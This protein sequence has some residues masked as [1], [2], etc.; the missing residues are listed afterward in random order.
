MKPVN[1]IFLLLLF[2]LTPGLLK[3]SD[4]NCEYPNIL[5]VLDKSSSMTHGISGVTKWQIAK[6]AI[7]TFLT[8]NQAKI[9]FGLML[10]PDPDKCNPGKVLVHLKEN[11]H[12]NILLELSSPPPVGG[13]YTPMAQSLQNASNYSGLADISRRNYVLLITDGWQWCDPYDSATRF[14]PVDEVT[15][16]TL[17]NISTFVIGFGGS[18]DVLTLNRCAVAGKTQK[19]NCDPL[20]NDATSNANCYFQADDQNGLVQ[21][22]TNIVQIITKEICDGKDNDCDGLTDGK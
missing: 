14:T 12:Q 9:R 15:N 11:N 10:F 13:N 1:I 3:A 8:T 17:K 7:D 16:L 22:L 19:A 5:I 2:F 20:S 4:I 18:V 6:E 21:A